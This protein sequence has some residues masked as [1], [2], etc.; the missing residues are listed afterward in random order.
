MILTQELLFQPFSERAG[1]DDRAK[2]E[3]PRHTFSEEEK[4]FVSEYVETFFSGG[5]IK[6]RVCLW[7]II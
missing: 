4:A 1:R 2:A 6:W 7:Q 5:D 3:F